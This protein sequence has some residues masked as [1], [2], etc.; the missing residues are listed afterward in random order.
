MNPPRGLGDNNAKFIHAMEL[1]LEVI[2]DHQKD[3]LGAKNVSQHKARQATDSLQEACFNQLIEMEKKCG[4]KKSHETR[5][6]HQKGTIL[7]MGE[8]FRKVKKRRSNNKQ[9]ERDAKRRRLNKDE[10]QKDN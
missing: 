1:A 2:D 3:L 4:L 7:A 6:K 10:E 8:R 5:I 9:A